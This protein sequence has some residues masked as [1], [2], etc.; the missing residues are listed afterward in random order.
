LRVDTIA[1]ISTAPGRSAIAVVRASGPLITE[2]ISRTLGPPLPERRPL[3]RWLSHPQA[4][5]QVDRVLATYFPAPHSYTGE[6]VLELSCHGGALAPQLVLDALLAAGARQAEPG[7]FT[8]RAF[9]NGKLD[10]LQAEAILDLVEGRSRAQHR[11]AVHQLERG[12][13]RR[14]EELREAVVRCEALLVYDIDFP[15]E[16]DGP[17]AGRE[18]DAAAREVLNRIERLL[19]TVTEG[20][21]LREGALTVIAGRPNAGKSSLFNALCGVERAIVTDEPGTTRDAV[22]A[23]VSLSGYPF[24]LVDTAGLAEAA[25]KLERLGIE[26]A[27]RYLA[28]ADVVLF[29]VEAGRRPSGEE[30]EFLTGLES[31]AAVVVR[32]KSDLVGSDGRRSWPEIDAPQVFVSTVTGEGLSELGERLAA[33][34]FSGSLDLEAETPLVTRERHARELRQARSE[35]EAF[36]E[37]RSS[38][39]PP[40]VAATHLRVA[41]QALEELLGVIA[42]DDLLAQV[43]SEFCIGK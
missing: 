7:E 11:A 36:L 42:P 39:L 6:D 37:A 33:T 15:D 10:L 28:G 34:A 35:V 4:G 2:I 8:R 16:D 30:L 14:I 31:G 12:L 20:E 18:I 23:L 21:L 43:F 26:V 13:S 24:R 3:L 17:V 22:E 41:A 19:D 29:C 25:G 27:R 5:E 38:A 9:L 1:A 32:T 40:E